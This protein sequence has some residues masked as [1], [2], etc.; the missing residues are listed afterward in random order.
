VAEY[1]NPQG[2][3]GLDIK[4]MLVVFAVSFLLIAVTQQFLSKKPDTTAVDQNQQK[5]QPQQAAPAS[6]PAAPVAAATSAKPVN[7]KQ[8]AAE[9]ETVVENDFY[10]ITFTNKGA[11]VKSWV[12]KKYKDDDGKPL[13]MVNAAASPT[14]GYPLSLW[15]WDENLRT[16]L[17]SALYVPGQTSS[18]LMGEETANISVATAAPLEGHLDVKTPVTLTF[19][20]SD[21]DVTVHKS[22]GFSGSP[23]VKIETSVIRGGYYVNALPA[24]P[25][26]FGDARLPA[27]YTSQQTE[28]AFGEDITR[29]SPDPKGKK[30]AGGNLVRGPFH[31]VGVADQYFAAIFLP[32]KPQDAS[33]ITLQNPVEVPKDKADLGKDPATLEK[34]KKIKVDV[35]GVAVGAV[36]GMNRSRL[37]VGPKDVDLLATIHPNNVSG[38]PDMGVDLRPV[39]DFGR[40]AFFARPLFAALR[41][42][43]KN[44]VHN[45]GWAIVLLTVGINIILLPL[46][47]I[48]MRSALK[49][50]KIAP[51]VKSIQDKYSKYKMTDPRRAEQNVEIQALY[52]Q[53]DVN[54]ASGCLPMIIQLPFLWAFYTMLG[55]AFELRQAH[56]F[57][58]KDLSS[59]DPYFLLPVLIVVTMILM[60]RMTPTAG[61][62]AEQQ[63][64]MNVMMPM[65][66]GF[67]SWRL[68]SG[69]GLYWVT[70]TVVG[71]VQ[72]MGMNRTSLG[73]DL[74]ALAQKQAKKKLK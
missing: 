44:A 51:L 71:I 12:L 62:S 11:M 68:A 57:W 21:G 55:S 45:W 63:R 35:A 40:F 30:I 9:A 58:L 7:V 42:I 26:G 15:T 1:H 17:N 25:S 18:I 59:P 32:D 66:I 72:Q 20:Y 65:M 37:Y 54:P 13:E 43:E 56:W 50:Q 22:F 60:Q 28:Y 41:W 3:S 10:K 64:M 19:D 14:F 5:A 33:L 47:I 6:S 74:R 46:R 49:M 24:W 36:N 34:D 73:R 29:L 69:L 39:V 2:D 53:H 16:R 61:V 67:F 4:R 31:W 27:S 70:G 23:E 52:K 8:A 48:S 38:H